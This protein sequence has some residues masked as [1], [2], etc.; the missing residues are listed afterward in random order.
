MRPPPAAAQLALIRAEIE[1]YGQS[2]VGCDALLVFVS[3]DDPITTQFGHIFL[4]ATREQWSIE[5]R[6]DG[7]VR[8]APLDCAQPLAGELE[9]D[10]NS[11]HA[12]QA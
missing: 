10:E 2:I 4:T 11:S 5:F 3:A 7:T 8:F 1:R 12:A 9:R 6:A